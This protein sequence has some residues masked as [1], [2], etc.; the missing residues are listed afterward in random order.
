[1]AASGFSITTATLT[2]SGSSL[3]PTR[4]RVDGGPGGG[5]R[6]LHYRPTFWSQKRNR[7]PITDCGFGNPANSC[8]TLYRVLNLTCAAFLL[9]RYSLVAIISLAVRRR[10]ATWRNLNWL[11][12]AL[13]TCEI[14]WQ[15]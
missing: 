11:L 2:V 12:P 9:L 6:W 4:K 14:I 3:T 5:R 13:L 1:M 15:R 8:M 7:A 10:R